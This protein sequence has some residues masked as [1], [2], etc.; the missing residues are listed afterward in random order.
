MPFPITMLIAFFLASIVSFGA[1][2]LKM[3]SP[4]GAMA[5][6]IVGTI[7]FACGGLGAAL[8]LLVFFASGSVL[9]RIKEQKTQIGLG[10]E[11]ASRW[12]PGSG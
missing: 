4:S 3:L 12:R 8:P 5:A 10:K 1:L 7:V 2:R 11:R 9:S 6:V